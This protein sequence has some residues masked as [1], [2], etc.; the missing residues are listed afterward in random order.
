VFAGILLWAAWQTLRKDPR[1]TRESRVT[2]LLSR[3]VPVTQEPGH[4]GFFVRSGRGWVAT[5]LLI[6]LC[7]VELVDIV[8]AVDSVP[9]ALSITR[10]PFLVY[11]SNAF[12]VLGLR[13]LYQVLAQVLGRL[14]YLHYGIAAV[15]AFAALKIAL[16][17]WVEIPPLASVAVVVFCIAAAAWLSPREPRGAAGTQARSV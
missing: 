2:Q 11:S 6:A 16:A 9:A 5:P 10:D 14:R 13:S 7:A 8:F 1:G 3:F 4:T 12:A 15:L 17:D